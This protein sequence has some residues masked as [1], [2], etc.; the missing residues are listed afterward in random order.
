MLCKTLT[1]N[2]LKIQP[3]GS[4]SVSE[5]CLEIE[6]TLLA[7]NQVRRGLKVYMDK[8]Q[9]D[10]EMLFRRLYQEVIVTEAWEVWRQTVVKRKISHRLV[11]FIVQPTDISF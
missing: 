10:R 9:N 6:D 5:G 3:F 2:S 7:L 8:G 1:S 11:V 4:S